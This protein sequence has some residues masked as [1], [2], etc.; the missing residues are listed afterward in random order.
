MRTDFPAGETRLR[1]DN[2]RFCFHGKKGTG[3]S[4]AGGLNALGNLTSQSHGVF[5]LQGLQLN[6][7]VSNATAG[8]LLVSSTRNVHLD[9]GTRMLFRAVGSAGAKP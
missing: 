2:L 4:S 8:S 9:S 1:I 7:E 3:S 6:S 5:G